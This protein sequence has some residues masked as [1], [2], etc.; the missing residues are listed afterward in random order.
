M[1][2]SVLRLPPQ[3]VG[4]AVDDIVSQMNEAAVQAFDANI[5]GL[6]Q[7]VS[8]RHARLIRCGWAADM[9]VPCSGCRCMHMAQPSSHVQPCGGM[10]PLYAALLL[11]GSPHVALV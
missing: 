3:V 7:W 1:Q 5:A 8:G 9:L 6:L 2:H 10:P 4:K 11:P